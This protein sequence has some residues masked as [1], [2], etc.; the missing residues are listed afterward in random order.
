MDPEDE[1]LLET[2]GE[3][4]GFTKFVIIGQSE[5]EDDEND[6]VTESMY[7]IKPKAV[8]NHDALRFVL[9]S[10]QMLAEYLHDGG[11]SLH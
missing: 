1:T 10:A 4:Y 11:G 2:L 5:V 8:T 9:Q 6:T 3:K 7:V